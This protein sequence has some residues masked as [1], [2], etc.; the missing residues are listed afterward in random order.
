LAST[1]RESRLEKAMNLPRLLLVAALCL[2]GC[3]LLKAKD[4]PS[5]AGAAAVP[6]RERAKVEKLIAALP[7]QTGHTQGYAHEFDIDQFEPA[8]SIIAAGDAAVPCLLAKL[9]DPT[10]TNAYWVGR[11]GHYR[12]SVGDVSVCILRVLRSEESYLEIV[13]T[14]PELQRSREEAYK[15]AQHRTIFCWAAMAI[16]HSMANSPEGCYA[17]L[18]PAMKQGQC[19]IVWMLTSDR[20][21]ADLLP[22]FPRPEERYASAYAATAEV[23]CAGRLGRPQMA[24]D[25]CTAAWEG[26]GLQARLFF[27]SRDGR[28]RLFSVSDELLAEIKR[29]IQK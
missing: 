15:P 20:L 2:P 13:R 16:A 8:K 26:H 19:N 5:S 17:A 21:T 29:R 27:R 22:G 12:L 4:A 11:S 14:M 3:S 7:S 28:W 10:P 25:A 6:Q 1:M 18:L 24:D 9:R 23:L